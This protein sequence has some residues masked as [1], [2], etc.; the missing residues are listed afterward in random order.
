MLNPPSVSST[1]LPHGVQTKVLLPC[2]IAWCSALKGIVQSD[3]A[4]TKCSKQTI[5]PEV[6]CR[7]CKNLRPGHTERLHGKKTISISQNTLRCRTRCCQPRSVWPQQWK[8]PSATQSRPRHNAERARCGRAFTQW[9][10]TTLLEVRRFQPYKRSKETSEILPIE[11]NTSLSFDHTLQGH[12]YRFMVRLFR[13][14]HVSNGTTGNIQC[15]L[16]NKQLDV[17]SC[18]FPAKWIQFGNQFL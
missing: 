5:Y 1:P 9:H 15:Q 14:R 17:C 7:C 3:T 10:K 12:V 13:W 2:S 4:V 18:A 11:R 16:Q 8:L 6:V